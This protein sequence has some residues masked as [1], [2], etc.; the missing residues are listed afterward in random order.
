[1]PFPPELLMF[2]GID[3]FVALSL[4]ASLLEKVFPKSFPYI[5]QVGG[6]AGF[7]QIWVNYAFLLPSA[8][9]RF[10]SCLL[11]LFAAILNIGAV[12]L[13]IAVRKK[14]S[15]AGMFLSLFTIPSFFISLFF[16][17]AYVNGISIPM[18]WLPIIPIES[19]YAILLACIILLSLSIAVYI[20]P[21]LV[22]RKGGERID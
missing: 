19:L 4:F 16:V 14:V 5:Y 12:N 2:I 1:M 6:L 13:Y 21:N 9:T 22:R 15:I 17:S 11:Y 8:E 10:W 3:L 7:G 20:E 18:P